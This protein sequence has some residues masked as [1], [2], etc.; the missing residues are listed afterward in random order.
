MEFTDIIEME[1]EKALKKVF[2]DIDEKLNIVEILVAK[3]FIDSMYEHAI[4]ISN[5]VGDVKVIQE[6]L[7]ETL[8]PRFVPNITLG[9]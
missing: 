9:K 5:I 6:F 8:K 3:C 4:S 7:E 1:P 2:K